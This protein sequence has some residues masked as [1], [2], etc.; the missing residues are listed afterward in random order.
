MTSSH[1][2]PRHLALALPAMLCL[3]LAPLGA[4]AQERPAEPPT[5]QAA[6]PPTSQPESPAEAQPTTQP[7]EAAPSGNVDPA[8]KEIL[9]AM[10]DAIANATSLRANIKTTVTGS[11]SNVTPSTEAVVRMRKA[12]TGWHI[13]VTGT[14]TRAGQPSNFDVAWGGGSVTWLDHKEKKLI[15][16]PQNEARGGSYAMASQA[17]PTQMIEA[18]P[19]NK[20]LAG[21]EIAHAGTE[22]VDGQAC[23]LLH[24]RYPKRKT[25][26]KLWIAQSDHMLRKLERSTETTKITSSTVQELTDVALNKDIPDAE[27]TITAP[28]GYTS[29]VTTPQH[30]D[31]GHPA[32]PH[33]PNPA[34]PA[35]GEEP[36]HSPATIITPPG[37]E[38]AGRPPLTTPSPAQA[39]GAGTLPSASLSLSDGS[40]LTTESLRGKPAVLM[41]WGTWNL[42]ARDAIEP[43]SKFA[44]TLKEPGVPVIAC[45]V[46]ERT[47]DAAA[48]FLKT[49]Q[50]RNRTG[51][52]KADTSSLKIAGSA[53]AFAREL[54]I[55]RYPT[56]LAVDAEGKIIKRLEG[57]DPI[58]TIE[59]LRLAVAP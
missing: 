15:G 27:L 34:A 38:S 32:K 23:D 19:F 30:F 45:A 55:T 7:A 21:D 36:A 41:F 44:A 8:A 51:D 37:A 49:F 22:E 4:R 29:D 10:S 16:R 43:L 58:K 35:E 2:R 56:F 14:G 57:F 50:P 48:E 28:D 53:D 40:T 42:P 9:Q 17:M 20:E 33:T 52:D 39:L 47:K 5:D 31:K 1:T 11:L 6:Q 12:D 24:V 46:R 26:L 54:A 25:L 3:A 59:E 13:R 18:V